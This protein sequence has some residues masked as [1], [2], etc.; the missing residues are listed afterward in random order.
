[1]VL[2]AAGWAWAE[3][4]VIDLSIRNG[5]LPSEARVV[6]VR[7]G[8]DVTLRWSTDRA[9][10]LHLHGYDVETKLAAG[11]T[12]SM[13]FQAKATGRFPIEAHADRTGAE[14]TLG[15]LEVHPR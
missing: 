2:A 14:R 9:L 3:A 6:R 13:R 11:A 10:T 1:M 5:E 4:R 7:Q 8:D 12:A 15:Y